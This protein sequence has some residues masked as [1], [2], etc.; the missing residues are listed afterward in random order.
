MDFSNENQSRRSIIKSLFAGLLTGVAGMFGVAQAAPSD[1]KDR[2]I[3]RMPAS[4]AGGQEVPLF[5]GSV[6]HDGLV[7]IAGKGYHEEG[8]ITKHTTEVLNSLEEELEKAG[9]SMDRVLKVNV[10]LADL[11]DYDEMNDAYRGRFGDNPP[12]RTTVATYG[13]VPGDSL[14]EI[15]CIAALN[16]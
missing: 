15:D 6:T 16:E 1:K 3:K 11:D 2:S 7:Y 5:S 10:Y 13:G 9:S 4:G 8:D 12:V 14:V